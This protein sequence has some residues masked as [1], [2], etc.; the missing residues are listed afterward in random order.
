[1]PRPQVICR[2]LGAPT[3]NVTAAATAETGDV[4]MPVWVSDL[5]CSGEEESVLECGF[6]S[7]VVPAA[8]LPAPPDLPL[9]LSVSCCPA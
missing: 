9:A 7:D 8:S 6:A 5:E 4:R 3:G 1:M 2:Q